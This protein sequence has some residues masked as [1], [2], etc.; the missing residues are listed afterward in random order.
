[1]RNALLAPLALMIVRIHLF[2]LKMAKYGHM[3]RDVWNADIAMPFVLK[4]PLKW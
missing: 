3:T 4:V 1:M 2:I